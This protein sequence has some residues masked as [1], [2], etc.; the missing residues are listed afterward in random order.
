MCVLAAANRIEDGRFDSIPVLHDPSVAHSDDCEALPDQLEVASPVFLVVRAQMVAT[1]VELDD[2]PV[3]DEQVH[4][5]HPRDAHL[6]S[7]SESATAQ[8]QSGERLETRLAAG[9]NTITD[10]VIPLWQPAKD[11]GQLC[12]LKNMATA[13]RGVQ[14]GV[15]R[16]DGGFRAAALDETRDGRHDRI[17]RCRARRIPGQVAPVQTGIRDLAE[18]GGVVRDRDMQ[19][20]V[21][22]G[23]ESELRQATGAGQLAADAHGAANV[24]IRG[25]AVATFDPDSDVLLTTPGLGAYQLLE[26]TRRESII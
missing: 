2:K 15:D 8:P 21:G 4:C 7:H 3:A 1:A 19:A 17:D 6:R 16:D 23:P 5:S 11:L 24:G 14:R 13:P 25:G 12:L 18:P 26:K 22:H 9:V 20:L 10:A